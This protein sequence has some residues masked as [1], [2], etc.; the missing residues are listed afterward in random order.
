MQNM[1]STQNLQTKPT[2]PNQTKPKLLAK[3]VNARVRSAFGNVSKV[4]YNKIPK[5]QIRWPIYL[6]LMYVLV[7]IEKTPIFPQ[8][9]HVLR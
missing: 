5:G 8:W 1:Q 6:F 2:K 4:L 9:I 7:L 3:A